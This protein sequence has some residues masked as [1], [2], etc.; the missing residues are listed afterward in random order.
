MAILLYMYKRYD[1]RVGN[2]SNVMLTEVSCKKL[3]QRIN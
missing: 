3:L 1:E 2:E